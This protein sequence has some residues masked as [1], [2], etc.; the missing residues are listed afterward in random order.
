MSFFAAQTTNF[1]LVQQAASA[2]C[3][4]HTPAY[5]LC[6]WTHAVS[7]LCLSAHGCT[8]LWQPF[9]LAE[10]PRV[11]THFIRCEL[12]CQNVNAAVSLEYI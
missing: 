6:R 9:S 11:L 3:I 4:A 7:D 8:K 2:Q 10:I 5:K 12:G 1:H